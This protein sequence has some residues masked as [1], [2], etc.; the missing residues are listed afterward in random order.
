MDRLGDGGAIGDALREHFAE[1]LGRLLLRDRRDRRGRGRTRRGGGGRGGGG[2]GGGRRHG[3]RG[4]RRRQVRR[5]HGRAGGVANELA[6]AERVHGEYDR[7]RGA[8]EP[9]D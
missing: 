9:Q 3:C 7:R 4:G 5:A 8:A 6:V 1:A 2:G